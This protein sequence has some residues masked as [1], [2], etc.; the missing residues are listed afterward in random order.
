MRKQLMT[1]GRVVALAA[2]GLANAQSNAC[3]KAK[4][5]KK[6]EG[7]VVGGVLGAVAGTLLA[8]KHDKQLGAAAGGA[9]GAVVGN[10]M[11]RD[12]TPCPAG[13]VRKVYDDKY[14]DVQKQKFRKAKYEKRCHWEER[15]VKD[16]KGQSVVEQL[17]VCK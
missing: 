17:Q 7:T 11:M 3:E 13:T 16:E 8:P 12:K 10:Q 5:D 6:V 1:F 14:Y 4:H 2:P 9:A 15:T